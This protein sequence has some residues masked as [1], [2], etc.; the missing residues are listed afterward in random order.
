L[1]RSIKIISILFVILFGM[2][3][4]EAQNKKNACSHILFILDASNS[5]TNKWETGR[6]IDVAK[7]MLSNIMDSLSQYPNVQVALRVYGHQK[8]VSPQDCSDTKLEIPFAKNNHEAIKTFLSRVQPRGTTPIARSLQEAAN[9]FPD[10][11]CRRVIVLLT[12]GIEACDGDPCAVSHDLQ[13]RGIILEPFV[14]GIGLDRGFQKTFEC[15]GKYYDATDE[16][17][18]SEIMEI[19]ITQALN[20]TSAQVNLLDL[21]GH[22]TETNVN[23]T[24]YNSLS[25]LTR[26]NYMHTLNYRGNPDTLYLDPGIEYRLKV[27][28]LPPIYVDSITLQQGIHNIIAVD[29]AMGFL[30]VKDPKGIITQP[31]KIIVKNRKTG[32]VIHVQNSGEK[33][34][35]R[36]GNYMLE[37]LTTPS[38]NIDSVNIRQN[39]TTTVEFPRPGIVNFVNNSEG[40][41]GIY[42]HTELGPELIQSFPENMRF[43]SVTLQPG[44]YMAMFRPIGKQETMAVVKREFEI[45]PGEIIRV[46]L[47]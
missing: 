32:E 35:Y 12:D 11:N 14:V 34:Q 45:K 29:A 16:S 17:R 44:K 5:M 36:T 13:Q 21:Y 40:Q 39:H 27:H 43:H 22:P 46:L 19:I 23:L 6:R 1:I 41:G 47:Y 4:I 30:L 24:F 10:D 20:T 26:Y 3:K 15:I 18:F 7:R 33:V 2:T 38:I 28:T 9:D 25:G 31:I 8:Q 37:V 42:H